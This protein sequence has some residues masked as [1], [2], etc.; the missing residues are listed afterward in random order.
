MCS[1]G[2]LARLAKATGR[3]HVHGVRWVVAGKP[4]SK[5]FEYEA[6]ADS[7]PL[8]AHPSRPRGRGFRY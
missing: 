1:S 2:N 3:K 6:Q 7:Y 4:F 8:K 5:W